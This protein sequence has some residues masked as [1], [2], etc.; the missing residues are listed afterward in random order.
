VTAIDTVRSQQSGGWFGF[1]A[2]GAGLAVAERCGFIDHFHSCM[3]FLLLFRMDIVAQAVSLA[4]AQ[5]TG[6]FHSNQRRPRSIFQ[7]EYQYQAI[8][9]CMQQIAHANERIWRYSNLANCRFR[10]T[11]YEHFVDGDFTTISP[12]CAALGLSA[13]H[14]IRNTRSPVE[15][16]SDHTNEQWCER[17]RREMSEPTEELIAKHEAFVIRRAD[18]SL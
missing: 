8:E 18:I 14:S 16:L 17:F 15:R 1:K 12:L 13:R 5:A 3:T 6:V 10:V 2:G 7:P 4:K 11:V 9:K